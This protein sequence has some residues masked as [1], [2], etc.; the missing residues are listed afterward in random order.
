MSL[1]AVTRTLLFG[2]FAICAAVV[3]VMIQVHGFFAQGRADE[4]GGL[5][6]DALMRDILH[7]GQVIPVLL[8]AWIVGQDNAVGPGR[9]AVLVV[10]RR[11]TLLG[12]KLFT[13]A[14]IALFAAITCT[15]ASLIPL[16]SI[17]EGGTGA[18]SPLP[19]GWV[20][21]YWVLMAV[22]TAAIVAASRNLVASVVS[23]LVWTIGLSD[24]LTAQI[25]ALSGTVD[26]AFK[27]VYLHGGPVPPASSLIG[28]AAQVLFVLVLSV[29]IY[30]WRDVR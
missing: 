21:G 6:V 2:T 9:L 28:V 17:A 16:A 5:T 15:S 30:R 12:A 3:F 18:L 25:P 8:G 20:I 27:Q 1:P 10:A 23:I 11:G 4:L 7:Y 14:G 29:A 26:Q 19:Y 24:L 13:T 22:L